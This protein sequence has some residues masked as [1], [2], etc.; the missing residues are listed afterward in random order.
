MECSL[1][2]AKGNLYQGS[3]VTTNYTKPLLDIRAILTSDNHDF[4]KWK[5]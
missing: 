3:V 1:H 4:Q 2:E 5:T